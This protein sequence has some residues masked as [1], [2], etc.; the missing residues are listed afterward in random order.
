MKKHYAAVHLKTRDF[1]CE[2]CG[3]AFNLLQQLKK[4][5]RVVHQ[6]KKDHICDQCGFAA[7]VPARL[8]DHIKAVHEKV[9][10]YACPI[11][12]KTFSFKNNMGA[13]FKKVHGEEKYI[14]F[15]KASAASKYSP[16][17]Q[18]SNTEP[19]EMEPA[20]VKI[21]KNN[22]TNMAHTAPEAEVSLILVSNQNLSR[23]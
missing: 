21:F 12:Q 6:K 11:C 14:K 4:H 2:I 22:S 16:Y 10:A 19:S 7:N 17:L 1:V 20:K 3:H 8:R 23:G 18:R 9:Q 13:H 15:M 5:T